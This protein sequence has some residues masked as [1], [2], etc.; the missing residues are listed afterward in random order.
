MIAVLGGVDAIG[1]S[2]GVGENSP[3]VRNA[4]CANS[5]FLGLKLEPDKNSNPFL[6]EDIAAPESAVR[7]F[8]VR[9]Q[10]DWA[11]AQAGWKLCR[12]G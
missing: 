8:V 6:D 2:A 7:I 4:T 10:E 1:F 3:E 12:T 5:S 9:A 11:I